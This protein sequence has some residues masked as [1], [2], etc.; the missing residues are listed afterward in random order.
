VVAWTSAGQDGSGSGVYAQRFDTN[1]APV[2]VE[3]QVSTTALGDQYAALIA[4]S[5]DDRL[6]LWSMEYG[7]YG[8]TF[9]ALNAPPS[10]SP[11][12]SMSTME[13]T[14]S[15]PVAIAASDPEGEPLTTASSRTTYHRRARSASRTAVSPIL[16]M[17]MPA[18]QTPSP[19]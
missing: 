16:R 1:G 18:V 5:G 13:D 10:T 15:S 4:S 12:A 9:S 11:T 14:P 6:I 3:F 17:P 19:S 8:R 2:G 7:I